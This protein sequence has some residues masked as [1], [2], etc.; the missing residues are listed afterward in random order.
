MTALA[1]ALPIAAGCVVLV[2]AAHAQQTASNSKA[3][4]RWTDK[5]GVV[6]YGDSVPAEAAQSPTQRQADAR[7]RLQSQHQQDYDHF[8]LQTYSSTMDLES[9]RDQ[10]LASARQIAQQNQSTLVDIDAQ[11]VAGDTD[12]ELK[13]SRIAYAA[14]VRQNKNLIDVLQAQRGAVVAHYANDLNRYRQLRAARSAFAAT[15]SDHGENNTALQSS[16]TH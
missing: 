7:I 1:L 9:A 16:S 11:V 14:A 2:C 6:H 10:Q 8:L 13:K 12:A 3:L 15:P 5:Q 4:Y